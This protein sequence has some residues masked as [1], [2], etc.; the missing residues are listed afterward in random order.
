MEKIY[1]ITD[2]LF[3]GSYRAAKK[4][5]NL[6]KN[7]IK[8][9]VGIMDK[10]KRDFSSNYVYLF[11]GIKDKTYIPHKDLEEI[12]DFIEVN[13]KKGNVLVNCDSG[14]SRSGGIV[15]AHLLKE[16]P[17]W[18]WDEARK[19][20][21]EVKMISPHPNIKKSILDY[22]EKLDRKKSTELNTTRV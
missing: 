21:R 11:K 3:I 9:I 22:F 2:K 10:K 12:L 14:I 4:E 8:A 6:S 19:Y 13:L 18:S 15:I 1:Q 20:V 7:N 16:K 17:D 5:K